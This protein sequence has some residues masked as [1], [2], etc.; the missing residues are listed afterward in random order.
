[1]INDP[2]YLLE[3]IH[4]CE[5][6]MFDGIVDMTY[7]LTLIGS[8]RS[9]TIHRKIKRS[10][11]SSTVIIQHNHGY[12]CDGKGLKQQV[13]F[14][15]I[16]HALGNVM[17]HAT[18]KGYENILVLEDDFIVDHSYFDQTDVDRIGEFTKS[19]PFDLYNLG[20]LG[21][22]SY[23]VDLYHRRA[24]H[25]SWAHAVIYNKR[26]FDK[27][28]K[29][30]ERIEYNIPCDDVPM[31]IPS[32][33]VYFYWKPI[34][35]QIFERTENRGT[36][37]PEGGMEVFGLWVS[38]LDTDYKNFQWQICIYNMIWDIVIVSLIV[39]WIVYKIYKQE[40][41]INKYEE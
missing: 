8:E 30:V 39:G 2:C 33:R 3:E 9:K 24:L 20:V 36:W 10:R 41:T 11:I 34:I 26:Y 17:R 32:A 15:D 25:S 23:P 38:G 12:K 28:I 31:S 35:F 21:P 7:C 13:S 37:G 27:Y 40:N 22:M 18:E 4:P 6:G 19:N 14:N 5:S 1:M 29:L 16:T